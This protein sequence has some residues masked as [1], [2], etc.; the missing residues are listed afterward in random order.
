MDLVQKTDTIEENKSRRIYF[1]LLLTVCLSVGCWYTFFS[2]FPNPVNE[3]VSTVL[4]VLLPPLLYFVCLAPRIGR[5]MTF[6]VFIIVAVLFAAAYHQ[7]WNGFLVMANIIVEVLN[8]QVGTAF[9]P[10]AMTGDTGE[11]ARDALLAM[12]P[13]ILLESTAIAYS[14]YYKEPLLGFVMT[15]IPVM[16]GLCFEARPSVWLLA[17]MI[18]CWAGL[19]VLS[20]VAKASARQPGRKGRR[21]LYLRSDKGSRLPYIFM[22][23]TLLLLAIYVL[24]F[25][26]DDYT[27][28]ESVDELKTE[29]IA[30]EE[31]LRYDKLTGDEVDGLSRGDLG[32]THPIMYTGNTVLQIKMDMVQPMYLRGFAGGVFSGDRWEAAPE[33]AYSG[34]YLGITEW[35]AQQGFYPWMQQD[36]MYRMTGDYDYFGARITNT[37]ASSKYMYLPYEAAMSDDTMPDVVDYRWDNGAFAKGLRGDREYS[38]QVFQRRMEDYSEAGVASWIADAKSSE[39]W[40]EYSDA[41]SVYRRFVYDTYLDISPEDYE[42]LKAIGAED[43]LGKTIEYTLHH[44][45]TTFEENYQYNVEQEAAPADRSELE[46]FINT[47]HTGNDMHFATAAALMFRA[48]GIPARYVEGYYITPQMALDY[49]QLSDVMVSILDSNAHSWVEIYIDELGWFPVEVIPGYYDMETTE[50]EEVEEQ[51]EAEENKF[52]YYQNEIPKFTEDGKG[53]D[54]NVINPLWLILLA[55]ALLIAVFEVIGRK[56][57]AKKRA[58][59]STV[60]S[61]EKVY[62]MYRYLSRLLRLDKRPLPADPYDRL[63]ELTEAYAGISDM[64]MAGFLRLVSQVRFGRKSVSGDQQKEM[65]GFVLEM[66]EHIYSRQNRFKRFLMKFILFCV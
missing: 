56:M 7:V 21:M 10:F 11:W 45:R 29:V 30:M 60:F 50:T 13:V 9:I 38:I 20:A 36:L 40:S 33:G 1:E 37:N 54:D 55:V 44:I 26:G 17:M 64:D 4:I 6:Y 27:P 61:D 35:L 48:S 24:A 42:V 5:F 58:S 19:L 62:E 32:D 23:V 46:Y 25:S 39:D 51:Q 65:A 47:S 59:F 14:V 16:T 49:D 57:G 18:L 8:D 22:S 31:H 3:V 15:A 34:E 53:D 43:C 41:E 2:M 63:E 66:A 28:P 52:T 12:I